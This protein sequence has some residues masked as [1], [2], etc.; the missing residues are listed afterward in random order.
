MKKH[1]ETRDSPLTRYRLN[2]EIMRWVQSRP[3]EL[4]QE[5]LAM[6]MRE[7]LESLGP[8]EILTIAR[9]GFAGAYELS[10]EEIV[11]ML[12][13]E[14]K[15]QSH[16]WVLRRTALQLRINQQTRKEEKSK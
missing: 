14:V 7:D 16:L 11:E 9:W 6:E 1:T 15:E 3:R 13:E 10:L 8:R 12:F 2:E 5:A 4:L